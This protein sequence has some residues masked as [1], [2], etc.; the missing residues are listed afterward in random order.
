M[1]KKII[2]VITL[3]CS[4]LLLTGCEPEEAEKPKSG[5]KEATGEIYKAKLD[6]DGN[7][8]IDKMKITKEVS[9]YSYEY[10]GVIISIL[11]VQDENGKNHIMV[12]TCTS[13]GGSPYA[14]FVQVNDKLQCQNCGNLF[15]ISKLDEVDE[16]GCNPIKIVN[17]E[18]KGN[19]YVIDHTEIEAY[20]DKFTNWN[21]P[22]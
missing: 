12:N 19:S 2:F 3:L 10:E 8:V 4:L 13:C 1:K 20:K 15:V 21:G 9:Y 7:I 5:R 22:K 18:E 14:Y 11:A 17:I 6:D 16:D